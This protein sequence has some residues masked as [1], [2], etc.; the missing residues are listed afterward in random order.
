VKDEHPAEE[1]EHNGDTRLG[2]VEA[3]TSMEGVLD[4]G[5]GEDKDHNAPIQLMEAE[6]EFQSERHAMMGA[7]ADNLHKLEGKLGPMVHEVVKDSMDEVGVNEGGYSPFAFAKFLA[8]EFET[9]MSQLQ[10][11]APEKDQELI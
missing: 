4:E 1:A 6:I 5:E 11:F 3:M 2:R 9:A 7:G 8:I 10:R